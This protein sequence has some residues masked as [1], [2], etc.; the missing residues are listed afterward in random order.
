MRL[1][2]FSAFFVSLLFC[3]PSFA[4]NEEPANLECST[5]NEEGTVI[6]SA[7]G[8]LFTSNRKT[9]QSTIVIQALPWSPSSYNL[10]IDLEIHGLKHLESLEM[11]LL[12][13]STKLYSYTLPLFKDPNFNLIQDDF[14]VTLGLPISSLEKKNPIKENVN[15]VIFVIQN[16]K[17]K[18]I[19]LRLSN[20]R[21]IKK[22]FDKGVVSIT[23]DD[24]YSSNYKAFSIMRKS[25]LTGTAYLI[26]DAINQNGYLSKKQISKMS[27]SWGISSHH[28]TP[29]TSLTQAQ[30][31]LELS[32]VSATL[33]KAYSKEGAQHF[34]YPLGKVDSKSY[35]LI[36]Q[37][38]K[39][40]RL[41]SGGFET[42]P[43]SDPFRIRAINV[44]P[45]LSPRELLRISQTAYENGDW[46]VFMFHFIGENKKGDLNYPETFFRSFIKLLKNSNIPVKTID[47]ALK[48]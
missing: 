30:L 8:C 16:K 25:R 36:K 44:T 37:Q 4:A 17:D 46:A 33:S 5:K 35:Q 1:L 21:L 38:F 47:E 19:K 29:V 39:S 7:K 18:A 20:Y 10:N 43:P 27:K 31:K 9:K 13:N 34:A 45:D 3:P 15:K 40:A 11:H 41:A 28:Q 48:L 2:K 23:F 24:G 22:K 26:P 32:K 42:L 12:H 14:N 6:N